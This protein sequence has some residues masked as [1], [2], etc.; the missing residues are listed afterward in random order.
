M[1]WFPFN[2][3]DPSHSHKSN[4][5]NIAPDGNRH[6]NRDREDEGKV[7]EVQWKIVECIKAVDDQT[8]CSHVLVVVE[9]TREETNPGKVS[10]EKM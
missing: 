1:R 7:R 10:T 2:P 3:F 6:R 4:L 8:A 9:V 5:L